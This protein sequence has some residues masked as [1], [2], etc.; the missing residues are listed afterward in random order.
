[1]SIRPPNA[2]HALRPLEQL[3]HLFDRYPHAVRRTLE[4]ADRLHFDLEE[5]RYEY[6]TETA[7]SGLTPI[8][9]L[10]QLAWAGA[11]DRYGG[12]VPTKIIEGL[13]HEFALIEELRYEAYF[14]TVWDLVR[15]ARS[16][17]ILCQGRGSAA[18]S[19]VC[20]CLGVTSVDPNE[21]DLL[22]ERFISRERGEAPDI[23]VDFEH[24]RREEV[25]QYIYEKYGRDRR[26]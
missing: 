20:Y 1:M 12:T 21:L 23:D 6:P 25:L 5:L 15:Y 24:Q 8:E 19:I 4:V 14:L 7:P 17:N 22:F 9:Y 10:K 26:E 11:K 16:R 2:Q 13:R 3:L 18:N